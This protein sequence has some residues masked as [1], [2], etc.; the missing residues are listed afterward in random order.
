MGKCAGKCR[1]IQKCF[2]VKPYFLC[3]HLL[4]YNVAHKFGCCIVCGNA[5]YRNYPKIP[6][7][8][9]DFKEIEM[10]NDILNKSCCPAGCRS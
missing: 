3:S 2:F 7:N 1:N 6:G 8:A 10:N 9:V 5:V 4:C